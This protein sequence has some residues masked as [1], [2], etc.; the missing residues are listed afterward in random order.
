MKMIRDDGKKA[1]TKSLF[2]VVC[3]WVPLSPLF[4]NDGGNADRGKS[5]Y[6]VCTACHGV[7]GAG[8]PAMKAPKISGQMTWYVRR[9][10]ELFRQGARGAAPGDMQGMQMA[11]MS[12][13]RQLRDEQSLA[14]LVAYIGTFP[15]QPPKATIT[16]DIK[17]GKKLYATCA[18]CHGDQGEGIEAMAAPRLARQSDWYLLAQLQKFKFGQ[19]GYHDSD[20]GGR[21]MRSMIMTLPTDQAMRDVVAYINTLP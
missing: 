2:W 11:A 15:D 9:Q 8:N 5:L 12:R 17:A 6:P 21:Q 16:A 4:A 7:A 10:L 14:D 20:H 13:G 18:S 3:L 1:M 19:R